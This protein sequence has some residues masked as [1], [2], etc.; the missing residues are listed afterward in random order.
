MMSLARH[1]QLA[2]RREPMARYEV[3]SAAGVLAPWA[4]SSLQ[5]VSSSS[6]QQTCA[7]GWERG[8]RGTTGRDA[9]GRIY[10]SL[11]RSALAKAPCH[12]HMHMHMHMLYK[13]AHARAH[14]QALLFQLFS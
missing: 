12:I 10:C 4:L 8:F 5:L 9:T 7:S 2:G 11:R 14:A 1:A 13:R 3:A 6:S